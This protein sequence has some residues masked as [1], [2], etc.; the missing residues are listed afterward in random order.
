MV[1]P[2]IPVFSQV[3]PEG[4]Q[5]ILTEVSREVS[6]FFPV[7]MARRV[8]KELLV[9]VRLVGWFLALFGTIAGS[10]WLLEGFAAPPSPLLVLC[11]SVTAVSDAG[12]VLCA[13]SELSPALKERTKI[14]RSASSTELCAGSVGSFLGGRNLSFLGDFKASPDKGVGM[15]GSKCKRPFS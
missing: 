12:T 8:G 10:S 9:H 2:L 11:A 5:S 4:F 13:L 1:S 15:T 7:P 14:H 3:W 6:A